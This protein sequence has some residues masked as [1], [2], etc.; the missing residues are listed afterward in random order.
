MKGKMIGVIV[1]T[2]MTAAMNTPMAMA[3][4]EKTVIKITDRSTFLLI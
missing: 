4:E 3:Q 1:L 2:T